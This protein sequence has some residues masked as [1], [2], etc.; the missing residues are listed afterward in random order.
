MFEVVDQM[1]FNEKRTAEAQKEVCIQIKWIFDSLNLN[2]K[3]E[4][5]NEY[6]FQ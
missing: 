3:A 4:F 6:L 5:L 1:K 2:I